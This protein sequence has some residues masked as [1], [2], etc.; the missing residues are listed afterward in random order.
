MCAAC[1]TPLLYRYLWAV[2]KA[3]A[4]LPTGTQVT[5][6]YYVT[7]PQI[8]LDTQPSLPPDV[9]PT[10]SEAVLPYLYLYP[11]RLHIPELFGFCLDAIADQTEPILLLENVPLTAKGG[12]YPTI[13]QAWEQATPVR[14]VYWLWQMLQLWTPL[15][16]QKVASSLLSGQ[17]LRVEGWRLHLCQLY[18][19]AEVLP[20]SEPTDETASNTEGSPEGSPEDAP[21]I[22]L[23][24]LA[25]LAN[26]WLGW[27]EAAHPTVREP[28]QAIC[29]QMQMEGIAFAAIATQLNHLLIEQAA[30]LPLRLQ[31]FG[32]TDAGSARSHNEDSCYPVATEGLEDVAVPGL[33]I[34]CDGIGGHEGGEVASQIAVRTLKLQAQALLKEVAQQ[35][36]LLTPD[37]LAQQLEA[38]VRVANNLIA[39]QNDLQG[40]EDRR[41]M[42]TTL[43]MALQIPQT[44]QTAGGVWAENGHELYLVHVGDSRAYWIT[45]HYCQPLTVDDDVAVREVRLGRL[46]YREA[47]LR[48]DAGALTQALGTR[49]AEFLH[50][51]VQ[52]FVLEEDGLLLLCS[53]GLSDNNLVEQFWT[54]YSEPV[55]QGKQSLESATQAWIDLANRKN[56]YDNTSVVLLHCQVLPTPQVLLPDPAASR[57]AGSEWS[58][59]SRA[60][61]EDA[62]P[63]TPIAPNQI[64]AS[65]SRWLLILAGL[66]ALLLLAGGI[67]LS[68]WNEINPESYR[69]FR[70][71][72]FPT[73]QGRS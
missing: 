9:P 36:E 70:E 67:G 71:R 53:D 7:A 2:G 69:Q 65:R 30:Q 18:R 64:P 56:G 5:G 43:M 48:S 68:V 60:L 63:E 1:Q 57:E 3:A 8:W 40:R 37:V 58:P 41:R 62:Q 34:V 13:V 33:A 49:D 35:P 59:A 73:G 19:D 10:W 28:L 4:A 23:L 27:L 25:D 16:E 50:P 44:V 54:E 12:L 14:Q 26:L 32:A 20:G 61:A 21:S 39:S 6:R 45:Q 42:G 55:L 11:H 38:S 47:L 17:N 52:R 46:L 24:K 29:R 66:L 72:V 22:E 15:V 31:I 51:T